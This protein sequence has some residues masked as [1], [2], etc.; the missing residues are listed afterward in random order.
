[1]NIIKIRIDFVTEE[2][3]WVKNFLKNGE[4]IFEKEEQF[5]TYMIVNDEKGIFIFTSVLEIEDKKFNPDAIIFDVS[6]LEIHEPLEEKLEELSKVKVPVIMVA[7]EWR[8]DD[9]KENGRIL[10]FGDDEIYTVPKNI[11]Y[12]ENPAKVIDRIIEILK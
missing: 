5:G 7:M 9:I 1:M 4:V 12:E 2:G 8:K 3:Y 11:K 10:D 6:H